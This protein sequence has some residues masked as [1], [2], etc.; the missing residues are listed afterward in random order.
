MEA[1]V[2]IESGVRSGACSRH[3]ADRPDKPLLLLSQMPRPGIHGPFLREGIDPIR[4]V[5]EPLKT[6]NV[7]YNVELL[8]IR[9]LY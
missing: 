3:G 6:L 4:A 8:V 7:L 5:P 9:L 1:V 2:A